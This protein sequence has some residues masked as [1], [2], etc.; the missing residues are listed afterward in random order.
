MP[1]NCRTLPRAP[2]PAVRYAV[3]VCGLLY[4]QER[5]RSDPN[6]EHAASSK[7]HALAELPWA[8][9]LNSLHVMHRTLQLPSPT[10]LHDE[11]I[12]QN[13]ACFKGALKLSGYGVDALEM[14]ESIMQTRQAQRGTRGA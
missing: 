2:R 5:K 12:E 9:V 6:L 7:G 10:S 13:F 4:L 14:A 1:T 3:L 11:G 8:T